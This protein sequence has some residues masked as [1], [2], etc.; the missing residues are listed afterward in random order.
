[1]RRAGPARLLGDESPAGA[2]LELCGTVLDFWRWAFGDLCP[3]NVRGVFAEWLV[4]QILEIDLTEVREPWAN[5]DLRSEHLR[6]EVKCAAYYQVW[7][8]DRLQ[9][10]RIAWSGLKGQVWDE[11]TNLY[12]PERT[13]N[14]D[15]YV[16]CVQTEQD[17]TRWNALDLDQWRFY[18]LTREQLEA[19][20]GRSLSLSRLKTQAI[21][22]TAAD[23]RKQGR[24][25]MARL[26]G[27][28]DAG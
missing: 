19:V 20:G 16:F 22:L 5:W 10:S 28:S 1:M 11:E 2:D 9:P 21:A 7:H 6:I 13:Y 4:A 18:L 3:N 27:G 17:P 23:L 12:S 24:V 8:R 25:L 14:A 15:L 26:Q